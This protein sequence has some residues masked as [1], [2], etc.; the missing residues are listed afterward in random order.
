[1]QMPS[2][3]AVSKGA[4]SSWEVFQKEQLLVPQAESPTD[5]EQL[6]EAEVLSGKAASALLTA[7]SA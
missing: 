5:Q 3:K 2:L 1:M 6:L 7:A 4:L